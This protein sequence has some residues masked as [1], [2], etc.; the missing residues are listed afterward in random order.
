MHH[1][2]GM[3]GSDLIVV[4]TVVMKACAVNSLATGLGTFAPRLAA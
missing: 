3:K 2:A 4:Q 1:R